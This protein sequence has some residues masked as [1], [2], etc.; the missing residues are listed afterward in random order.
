MLNKMEN[1]Q[2]IFSYQSGTRIVAFSLLFPNNLYPLQDGRTW[3]RLADVKNLLLSAQQSVTNCFKKTKQ[4]K[5][6]N[7]ILVSGL[8]K[9]VPKFF[10][11]LLF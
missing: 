10:L 4:K 3:G 9:I 7:K 2:E 5:P 1:Y 8:F 11:A 6:F